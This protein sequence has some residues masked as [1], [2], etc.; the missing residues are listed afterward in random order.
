MS[1]LTVDRK[2]DAEE[3]VDCSASARE[4]GSRIAE[5]EVLVEEGGK[6]VLVVVVRRGEKAAGAK[7][8][9]V[10]GDARP[11]AVARR[12]VRCS[13]FA[14]RFFNPRTNPFCGS[15]I[16]YLVQSLSVDAIQLQ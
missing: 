2:I 10:E 12:S 3:A 1:E 9:E 4:D 5:R 13:M 6:A 14:L 7:A 16:L 15:R 8:E 11:T